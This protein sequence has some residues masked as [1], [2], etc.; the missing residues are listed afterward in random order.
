MDLLDPTLSRIAWLEAAAAD[1][2][3]PA[4]EVLSDGWR[5][6]YN[7][8]VTRRGNSVLP[9]ARGERPL[10]HKLNEVQAFY[11]SR[12]V[13]PR[14]QLTAASK[15][16]RLDAEL[17]R[18]GWQR[19]PGASVLHHGLEKLPA[20]PAADPAGDVRVAQ[21]PDAGYREV[22]DVVVPGTAAWSDGRAAALNGAGLVPWH[23]LIRDDDGRAVAA[24]LA[25][26]DPKRRCVG[27]FSLATVPDAR[28]RGHGRALVAAALR[29]ARAAGA[30]AAYLQVDARNDAALR[31]YRRL[32]FTVHHAYHYRWYEPAEGA[33][34]PGVDR[35]DPAP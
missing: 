4:E 11:R 30:H 8:G 18:K 33:I 29:R 7:G 25:V 14:V 16:P 1:S 5:L 19:E 32:G 6:R 2:L 22:Q 21:R 24:G 28:G 20:V 17:G 10:A 23:L 34:G 9:E 12:G 35:A 13:V 15:P 27:L 3:A 31:L 26:L